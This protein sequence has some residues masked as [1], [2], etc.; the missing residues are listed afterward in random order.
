[1]NILRNKTG[2]AGRGCL[3]GPVC[4]AGGM[5]G[6][7]CHRTEQGLGAPHATWPM[8]SFLLDSGQV[9]WLTPSIWAPSIH[10]PVSAL[11]GILD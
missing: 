1:M 3:R 2:P 11:P 10:F 9:T 4:G 8:Q 6:E 7:T 5:R